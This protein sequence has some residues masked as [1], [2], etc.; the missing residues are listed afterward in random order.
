MDKALYPISQKMS[1]QRYGRKGTGL[2]WM[3]SDQWR[4]P[5][6]LTTVITKTEGGRVLSGMSGVYGLKAGRLKIIEAF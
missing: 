5:E 1:S 4:G 6:D 3:A 2:I